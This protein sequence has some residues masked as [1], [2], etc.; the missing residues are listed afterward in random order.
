MSLK[1]QFAVRAVT[2]RTAHLTLFGNHLA[3]DLSSVSV[4]LS[5]E[6]GT[7][8]IILVLRVGHLSHVTSFVF[9]GLEILFLF[10]LVT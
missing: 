3:K 5:S 4:S 9:P 2:L 10:P 7:P 1:I 8:K 6:I